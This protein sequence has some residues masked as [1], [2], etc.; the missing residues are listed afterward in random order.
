VDCTVQ[1]RV[2]VLP[3]WFL[4]ADATQLPGQHS[5]GGGASTY[6]IELTVAGEGALAD[7]RESVAILRPS[8][9]MVL[10]F[11]GPS[12]MRRRE[13]AGH[14]SRMPKSVQVVRG[15]GRCAI[16]GASACAC[17]RADRS[18]SAAEGGG[19][20]IEPAKGALPDR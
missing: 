17:R 16:A 20:E 12:S 19:P 7:A 6:T 10:A 14:A 9:P 4:G 18:G 5:G 11:G 8:E 13:A 15:G 2:Q 3:G 1:D